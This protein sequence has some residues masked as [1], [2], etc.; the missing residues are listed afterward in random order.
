MP[1]KSGKLYTLNE[2]KEKGLNKKNYR[3]IVSKG[4]TN[5]YVHKDSISTKNLKFPMPL[6]GGDKKSDKLYEQKT[7]RG[8]KRGGKIK[9]KIMK[10]KYGHGGKLKTA[11]L[12]D[13]VKTT[14]EMGGVMKMYGKGGQ[15]KEVGPNQKGL[16]KLPKEVRNNMG[17][18]KKGGMMKEYGMGGKMEYKHGGMMMK[19][20]KGLPTQ[21]D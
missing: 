20:G 5:Y 7:F 6:A 14:Y 1:D 10:K 3:K 12:L 18:M 19:P 16:A 13:R 8:M 17:Y 2:L 21:H 9:K 11:S 4:M 15:L